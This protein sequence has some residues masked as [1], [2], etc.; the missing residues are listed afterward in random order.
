MTA[1]S[2]NPSLR[3]FAAYLAAAIAGTLAAAIGTALVVNEPGQGGLFGLWATRVLPFAMAIL[4]VPVALL[5]FLLHKAGL[6]TLPAFAISG[7][8][9]PAAFFVL[10]FTMTNGTAGQNFLS[11][12]L[13]WA[14]SG[15]VGGAAFHQ[16]HARLG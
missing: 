15:A 14:A 2:M 12:F 9:L 8:A 4:F 10:L 6:W 11:L 5:T 13:I 3:W 1:K 7:A 16:T